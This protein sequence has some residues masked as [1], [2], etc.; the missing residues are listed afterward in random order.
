M[1]RPRL[2]DDGRC[3]VEKEERSELVPSEA[4]KEG[5]DEDS[6]SWK[7]FG[8]RVVAVADWQASLISCGASSS[9]SSIAN[10]WGKVFRVGCANQAKCE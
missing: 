3:V 5:S 6:C 9:G 10:L 4:T 8:C 7:E 2:E 1:R